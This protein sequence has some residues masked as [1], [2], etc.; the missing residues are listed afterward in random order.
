V[1]RYERARPEEL[2]HVDVKKL[3]RI[4]RVGHRIT[5]DPRRRVR[6]LGWEY[7]HVAVDDPSLLAYVE[8][9]ANET[10]ARS[11]AFV[12]GAG[13]AWFLQR[14]I[15]IRRVM[16]DNAFAYLGRAFTGLC[17]LR[18]IRHLR[19][20]PY[21]P[22]TNAKAERFIRTLLTG[23][24]PRAA[25]Y[26]LDRP[27][28]RTAALAAL[29]QLASPPHQFRWSSADHPPCGRGQFRETSQLERNVQLEPDE[30]ANCANPARVTYASRTPHA[31]VGRPAADRGRT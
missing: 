10:G 9:L 4:G 5:G 28:R 31:G 25:L 3:G 6:G 21:T 15:R 19:T 22:R 17:E 30:L 27:H 24:G 14:G 23:V 20:R 13:L 26:V 7:V 29:L 11:R 2:L 1:Q 8:V 18:G 16:T 12:A